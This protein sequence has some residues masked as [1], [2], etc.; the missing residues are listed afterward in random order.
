MKIHR[1]SL[2]P[3]G[4]TLLELLVVLTILALIGAGVS[5]VFLDL[6]RTGYFL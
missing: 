2:H 1:P 5:S 4:L 3:S 6:R